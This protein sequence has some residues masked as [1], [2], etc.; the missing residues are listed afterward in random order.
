[1][2]ETTVKVVLFAAFAAAAWFAIRIR[3][4]CGLFALM[5]RY[6]ATVGPDVRF[7]L[8]AIFVFIL[9]LIGLMTIGH[10]GHP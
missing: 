9:A 1:M 10:R 6:S 3:V 8:L 4:K 7:F 5:P 2:M